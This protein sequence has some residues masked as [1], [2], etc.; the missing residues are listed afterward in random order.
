MQEVGDI[1]EDPTLKGGAGMVASR[2]IRTLT[3]RLK[4]V[5]R[6]L[7]RELA[8]NHELRAQVLGEEAA[9][10]PE[11]VL[12]LSPEGVG[13]PQTPPE[14]G[15]GKGGYKGGYKAREGAHR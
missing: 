5:E 11:E 8:H 2:T 14:G 15:R 10:S 7:V 13:L 1:D 6:N 3:N 4:A 12:D 9:L